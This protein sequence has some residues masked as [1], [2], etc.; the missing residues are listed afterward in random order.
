MIVRSLW[1]SAAAAVA[2]TSKLWSRYRERGGEK[3]SAQRRDAQEGDYCAAAGLLRTHIRT[4]PRTTLGGASGSS[5]FSLFNLGSLLNHGAYADDYGDCEFRWWLSEKNVK[6]KKSRI[7]EAMTIYILTGELKHTVSE[8]MHGRTQ[9][10]CCKG[11]TL[12]R[13]CSCR[14]DI[15]ESESRELWSTWRY[16]RSYVH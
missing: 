5:G 11:R 9:S 12:N 14:V 10:T 2:A 15:H 1:P 3:V 16:L 13:N 7:Y 8:G 4:R 6:G